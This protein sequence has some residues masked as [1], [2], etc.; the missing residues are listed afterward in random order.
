MR[1]ATTRP[2]TSTSLRRGYVTWSR[3]T[4]VPGCVVPVVRPHPGVYAASVFSGSSAGRR[5]RWSSA[6][7]RPSASRTVPPRGRTPATS[8]SV[9]SRLHRSVSRA[10]SCG[11]TRISPS[12]AVK[13]I[14][15]GGVPKNDPLTA[16]ITSGSG[17]RS[18]RATISLVRS[19]RV[20]CR[21]PSGQPMRRPYSVRERSTAMTN[22]LIGPGSVCSMYSTPGATVRRQVT[23]AAARSGARPTTR[24]SRAARSLAAGESLWVARG[25]MGRIVTPGPVPV[26]AA[27]KPLMR[28]CFKA[29][30]QSGGARTRPVR[31]ARRC[32]SGPPRVPVP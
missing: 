21:R 10:G 18:Y 8:R 12:L 9:P 13:P 26:H 32:R 11:S 5:F 17:T 22:A 31:S 2:V 6:S 28:R 16:A 27:R 23:S 19:Q 30:S 20:A 29:D 24:S 14:T 7:M 25:G 15:S 3:M 4:A 1:T